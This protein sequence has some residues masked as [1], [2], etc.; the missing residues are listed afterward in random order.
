MRDQWDIDKGPLGRAHHRGA[1]LLADQ[2]GVEY[3]LAGSAT[4][5]AMLASV[6]GF[7][8]SPVH[9]DDYHLSH[10]LKGPVPIDAGIGLD[11]W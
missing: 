2:T 10:E 9:P 3:A 5:A 8:A 1:Y 7:A 6:Q 11:D 4:V